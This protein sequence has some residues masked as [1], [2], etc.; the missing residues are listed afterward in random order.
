M[1]AIVTSFRNG[2]AGYDTPDGQFVPYTDAQ[3]ADLDAK[4]AAARN[5]GQTAGTMNLANQA[6]A[7]TLPPAAPNTGRFV[8]GAPAANSAPAASQPQ[9]QAPRQ[10]QTSQQFGAPQGMPQAPRYSPQAGVRS[11]ALSPITNQV[12]GNYAMPRMNPNAWYNQWQGANP[13]SMSGN[14]QQGQQINRAVNPGFVQGNMP[15]N[16]TGMSGQSGFQ[17][18]L[19]QMLAQYKW[20]LYF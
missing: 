12:S 9:T 5:T 16:F 15:S 10:T 6:R 11:P 20:P 19:A 14:A 2:V 18:Q 7:G 17:D 1:M 13:F 3:R 4:A 8:T